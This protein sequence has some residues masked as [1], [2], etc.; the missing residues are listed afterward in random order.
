MI[1]LAP[2]AVTP[3]PPL[4]EE[5]MPLESCESLIV[6]PIFAEMEPKVWSFVPFFFPFFSQLF[7]YE[8][9]TSFSPIGAQ[10]LMTFIFSRMHS[11]L[12]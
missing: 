3:F 4:L 9:L 8:S 12:K 5:G 6:L 11:L 1:E 2:P 7:F 10:S